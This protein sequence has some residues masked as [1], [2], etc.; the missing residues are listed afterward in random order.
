MNYR[1][2]KKES[3]RI[4]GTVQPLHREIEKNFEIVPQM[5][6]KAA[7]DGTLPKLAAMIDGSLRE[8]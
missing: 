3:F 5:W 4:A 7:V 6:Y 8:Y 1:I 2:E